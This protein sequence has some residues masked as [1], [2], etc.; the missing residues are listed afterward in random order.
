MFQHGPWP[1]ITAA[2]RIWRSPA[3]AT[4]PS[5]SILYSGRAL[6]LDT[7]VGPLP[8]PA[9]VC[10]ITRLGK[11]GCGRRLC[12]C[13]GGV[14]PGSG[15]AS[16]EASLEDDEPQSADEINT[17]E[18]VAWISNE[19]HGHGLLETS[20]RHKQSERGTLLFVVKFS[21]L[22]KNKK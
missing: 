22:K 16:T 17:V 14:K 18:D 6:A 1:L 19:T 5:A 15:V 12:C 3:A 11:R 20:P 8:C 21:K 4:A 10:P 13:N 7:E 2:R 9:G